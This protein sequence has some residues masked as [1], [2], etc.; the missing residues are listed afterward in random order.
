MECTYY[1]CKKEIPSTRRKGSKF[2]SIECKCNN[3]K[4]KKYWKDKLELG[5]N[6]D[7]EKV[8]NY[9]NIIQNIQKGE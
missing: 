7:M 8:R 1:N 3:R 2:C 9:K 6:Q 4:M 5:I